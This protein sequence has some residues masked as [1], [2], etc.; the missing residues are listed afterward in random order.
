[1][2]ISKI[3]K[4]KKLV[5]QLEDQLR[6]YFDEHPN[7]DAINMV[8]KLGQVADVFHITVPL[9]NSYRDY[10]KVLEESLHKTHKNKF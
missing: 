5:C 7:I 8:E 4:S 2:A 9:V 6:K 1:M 3:N 10:V